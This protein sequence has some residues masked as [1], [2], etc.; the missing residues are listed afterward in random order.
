MVS[1]NVARLLVVGWII[2]SCGV[3]V[4]MLNGFQPKHAL[5]LTA[6]VAAPLPVAYWIGSKVATT[7]SAWMAVT[8]G[9]ALSFAFGAWL[10]WDAF[11]GPSSRSES[12]SGL[13]VL[14]G[15][16]YQ[17]VILVVAL[18]AAGIMSRRASA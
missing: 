7:Q 4:L 12:L 16:L 6:W 11:L 2:L 18:V 9:L 5:I 3:F 1:M 14:Y 17:G 10:Y 15:P 8:A 13:V